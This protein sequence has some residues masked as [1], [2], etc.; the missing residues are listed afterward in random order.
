MKTMKKTVALLVA[1]SMIVGCV[2]GATLAWLT[3]TSDEVTNTFTTSDIEV[4][5][6]E[7]TGGDH[8][9][10]KMIPGYTIAKDPVVTVKADSEDCWLFVKVEESTN[11]KLED[12][13]TYSVTTG[14]NEWTQGTG[15]DG[16]GIPTNVYY[17][18]V[19]ASVVDQ[20]FC[21]LTGNA[22]IK[23]CEDGCVTVKDSVTKEMMTTAKN[24][25]PTLT[26]TAYASQ[27]YK[28]NVGSNEDRTFTAAEAWNNAN[29]S[30]T[31][32]P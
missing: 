14:E 30:A 5:L 21:V 26:F 19:P 7:T 27:L 25:Q 6:N 16:D 2:I 17:R 8:R 3:S 10:F 28:S 9:E 12:Y 1:V 23:D 32:T 15:P 20:S 24:S 22:T 13:I 29:S 18:Q 4:T 31:P 11:P